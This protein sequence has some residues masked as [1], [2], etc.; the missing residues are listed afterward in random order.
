M[1]SKNERVREVR[2]ATVARRDLRRGRA[3]RLPALVQEAWERPAEAEPRR[4]PVFRAECR[5]VPRPCPF[6]SC[7]YHL[8]LD[9]NEQG[10]IRFNFP[11][12]PLEQ[13]DPSCALDVVDDRGDLAYANIGRLMNVTRE[14]ARQLV[15]A[16][17]EKIRLAAP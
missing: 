13:L 12:L 11:D 6:V 14:G 2:P 8:Y 16:A 5:R 15:R 1:P 9:V 17:L 10:G 3:S 4:L 7:R